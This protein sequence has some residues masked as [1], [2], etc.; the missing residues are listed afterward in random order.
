MSYTKQNFADG[1]ILTAE[2]MNAIEDQIILNSDHNHNLLYDAKGAANI[3]ETNAKLYAD[4]LVQAAI[5]A[6][7]EASY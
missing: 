6:T 5:N 4:Q 7:W 2:H 1:D 3:A